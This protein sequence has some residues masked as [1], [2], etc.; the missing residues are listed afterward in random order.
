MTNP[1]VESGH[2][3]KIN[4]AYVI[5]LKQAL[6]ELG[7][8]PAPLVP[9][10]DDIKEF[11]FH[12]LC[13]QAAAKAA[14]PTFA[15]H[16][17]SALHL[18]MHGV[19]GNA[20]MSCRTLEHAAKFLTRH[21]P[22]KAFGGEVQF[23]LNEDH[24]IITM[25]EGPDLP[26][27]PHF[28]VQVFF[29]TVTNSIREMVG[30]DLMRCRVEFAFQP[31]MPTE[32]YEK[33]FGIPV[34]FGKDANRFIGPR[35]GLTL[36]LPSSENELAD[37][38]VRECGRLLVSQRQI[39]SIAEKVKDI[40]I[41]RKNKDANL[42]DTAKELK[43]SGR[44]LRRRLS[45]ERTSFREIVDEIRNDAAIA[46]LT[47]TRMPI[48]EIAHALNFDDAA[49]FRRAF[50]RWNDCSPQEFRNQKVNHTNPS[51]TEHID[52]LASLTN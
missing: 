3:M 12:L 2:H 23:G 29:I 6:R 21:N 19:F 39:G 41:R 37:I 44:T 50:R 15:L 25:N 4:P 48:A 18:G 5:A 51:P 40:L 43:M 10:V 7:H 9:D 32:L 42:N 26:S 13:E 16:F 17:G 8:D 33:F 24:A 34:A 20:I 30:K 28:L 1:Q 45:D 22:L 46:Y 31:E 14:D 47:E 36:A 35:D 38:F 11:D 49:N 27:A 52:Q